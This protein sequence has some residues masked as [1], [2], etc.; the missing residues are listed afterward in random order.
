MVCLGPALAYW[1]LSDQNPDRV[2]LAVPSG[3][4]RP[5][6]DH[7]PT[8]VHVFAVATFELGRIDVAEGENVSFSISDPERTVVDCFRLRHRIG[9]ELAVGG[10]RRYLRRPRSQ[11]G[12][13]LEL[14]VQLRVRMP[15]LEAMRL[16]QE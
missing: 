12:R 16:I 15:I 3:S 1:D 8:Q 6:I 11:A 7:P 4:H 2:D 14:A 9:V 13:V 10:L 5:H